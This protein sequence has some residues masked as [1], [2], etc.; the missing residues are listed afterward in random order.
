LFGDILSLHYFQWPSN[1]D[2][3]QL[4]KCSTGTGKWR[5]LYNTKHPKLNV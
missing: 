1:F 2:V 3:V 5:I 4:V